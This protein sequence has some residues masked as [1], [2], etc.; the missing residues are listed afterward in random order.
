MLMIDR[1]GSMSTREGGTT[2]LAQAKDQAQALVRGLRRSQ[3]AM[4]VAFA[5]TAEVICPFTADKGML[6]DRIRSI[7]PSDRLTRLDEAIRLAKAYATPFT[8]PEGVTNRDEMSPTEPPGKAVVFSDGAVG[9]A[10]QVT[11]GRLKLEYVKIG[12]SDNNIG[13]TAI[14]ARREYTNPRQ[15]QMFLRLQNFSAKRSEKASVAIYVNS[16][17]AAAKDIELPP[18]QG[19]RQ[20]DDTQDQQPAAAS[21]TDNT[22]SEQ[23]A[24]M[25]ASQ[26]LA[27]DLTCPDAAIIE[28]R[29]QHEDALAA[30]NTAR[31]CLP[32]AKQSAVLL[33]SNGNLF[34]E[35][36]LAGLPLKK[37]QIVKPAE[38]AKVADG[39]F[40]VVIFDR[41]SPA[42]L[43][44]GNFLF[45]GCVPP[46]EGYR[47]DP[48]ARQA[49]VVDFDSMHPVMRHVS[50]D[51]ILVGKWNPT[52]SPRRS[53][54][55]RNERRPCH[56][57]CLKRQSADG[58]RRA[59]T[60]PTRS[61]PSRSAS[62]YSC[63]TPCD[64]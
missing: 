10:R 45:F 24:R 18:T 7:A 62:R 6:A 29:L 23:L 64:S 59:S 37:F 34:L 33:V 39:A 13:I 42:R 43:G 60:W 35:K 51:E 31:I 30:D 21:A 20:T 17:L 52:E 58:G 61:G 19:L 11:L 36:V 15:V 48:D 2:R 47:R 1:S 63:I 57:L 16:T 49:Y 54:T 5:D 44:A 14:E 9:D 40:D 46:L 50:I 53:R 55:A 4:V 22:A 8:P 32:P 25:T 26:T 41:W 12:K 27:F 28:A 3:K 38:Y 56:L